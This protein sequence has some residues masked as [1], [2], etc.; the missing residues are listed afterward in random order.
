MPPRAERSLDP[1]AARSECLAQS[2]FSCFF[3]SCPCACRSRVAAPAGTHW[4]R[5]SEIPHGRP[6][7]LLERCGDTACIDRGDRFLLQLLRKAQC[8]AVIAA[9]E[10]LRDLVAPGR[11]RRR[12]R[13][14]K[15]RLRGGS[16]LRAAPATGET[17]RD[18]QGR[19]QLRT[20]RSG[21]P[22]LQASGSSITRLARAEPRAP[23]EDPARASR[24]ACA[25]SNMG[26]GGTQQTFP[27]NRAAATL[28]GDR[29]RGAV[30][31]SRG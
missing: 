12:D 16:L 14:R 26:P 1:V 23:G 15:L 25:Q 27:R 28:R 30:R 22:P 31:R 11:Q 2:S 13:R 6:E 7:L 8:P 24:P 19:A 3:F 17:E 20:F 4:I 18:R 21:L 10:R 5:E 29:R 9:G